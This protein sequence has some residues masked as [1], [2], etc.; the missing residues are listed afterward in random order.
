MANQI[1]TLSATSPSPSILLLSSLAAAVPAPTRSLYASTK[2]ASLQLYQSLAIEHPTIGFS[3]VLPSTVE[4]SFRSSAVDGGK[5]RE[6]DPE[7]H[8]LKRETV[9]RRCVRAVDEGDRT[10]YMPAFYRFAQVMYWLV[11]S[12]VEWRA[13]VKY[14]FSIDA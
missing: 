12:Y 2:S 5:P 4:G 3:F 10:V 1:P 11:P 6:D 14:N 8:G 9:A 13:R 7:A